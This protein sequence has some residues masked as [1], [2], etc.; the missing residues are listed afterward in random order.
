MVGGGTENVLCVLR[1][2]GCIEQHSAALIALSP[3]LRYKDIALAFN[4]PADLSMEL[5]TRDDNIHGI[6][7]P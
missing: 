2:L 5:W 7:N 3:L 6:S 4:R 1:V